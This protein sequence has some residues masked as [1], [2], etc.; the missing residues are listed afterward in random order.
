[1]K[2]VTLLIALLVLLL[3][4]A[5]A[6]TVTFDGTGGASTVTIQTGTDAPVGADYLVGTANGTL[7]A[8]IAVGTTPGGELGNTWA[9]PTLDHD[10]LDDQY[11]DSEADLTALLDNDYVDEDQAFVGEVTGPYSAT[12]IADSVTVTGWTMGASV[13]TNPAA[14]DPGFGTVYNPVAD[15]RATQSIK[16]FFEEVFE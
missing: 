5:Y 9:S 1:M 14:N 12:V 8:E 7:T 3:G 15:R 10:A 11:Y 2:T 13:A 6:G 16:N 4:N